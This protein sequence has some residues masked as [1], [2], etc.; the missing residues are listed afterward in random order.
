MLFYTLLFYSRVLQN[1]A[2]IFKMRKIFVER[3]NG[4]I[5]IPFNKSFHAQHQKCIGHSLILYYIFMPFYFNQVLIVNSPLVLCV[6]R[7]TIVHLFLLPIYLTL[8]LRYMF[9]P[10]Q[11]DF[12]FK[13]LPYSHLPNNPKS[14]SISA[15][16]QNSTIFSLLIWR[17]SDD[18]PIYAINHGSID[19]NHTCQ[20]LAGGGYMPRFPFG[21]LFDL[22]L[23]IRSCIVARFPRVKFID[24]YSGAR[25]Q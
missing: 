13:F 6:G 14:G 4:N 23:Y 9:H 2:Y 3:S 15:F 10:H 18:R 1:Q 17:A 16:S 8:R 22:V 21:A 20:Y 5:P 19:Y 24:M 7:A 25:G 11:F 12:V